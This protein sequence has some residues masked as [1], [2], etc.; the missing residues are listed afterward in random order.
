MASGD[1]C[2]VAA[3]RDSK[4]RAAG[5]VSRRGRPSR[6]ERSFVA[7]A[8]KRALG[9][10]LYNEHME[11]EEVRCLV[12][13][14]V[15]GVFFRNFVLKH[16]RHLAL[17]GYV[18]NTSNFKVEVVAQGYEDKLKKLIEYLHK[19]PFLSHVSH[20]DVEWRAPSADLNSFEALSNQ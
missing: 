14:K 18:K 16:A 6:V 17:V 20:V 1:Y 7:A 2:F 13:G 12:S 11:K 10:V 15:Q 4:A 8:A 9:R 19:G 5:P 3:V